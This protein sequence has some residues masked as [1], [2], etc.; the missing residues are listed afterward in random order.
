MIQWYY[1]ND[2][3]TMNTMSVMSP[4]SLSFADWQS[5]GTVAYPTGHEG[6]VIN[7]GST[8]SL[9]GFPSDHKQNFNNS[10]LEYM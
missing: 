8:E 6:C 2:K 4:Q 10:P 9:I 5:V 7:Y 3:I 1:L